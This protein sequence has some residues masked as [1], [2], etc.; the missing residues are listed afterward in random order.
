MRAI[1]VLILAVCFVSILLLPVLLVLGDEGFSPRPRREAPP[2][3]PGS[4][5]DAN[6]KL[7]P[8]LSFPAVTSAASSLPAQMIVET[9]PGCQPCER[10]KRGLHDLR[11]LGWNVGTDANDHFQ[12]IERLE[13]GLFP[14]ITLYQ[15]G[16]KIEVVNSHD[17]AELSVL[18]RKTW[19]NAGTPNVVGSAPVGQLVGVNLDSVIDRVRL[20]GITSAKVRWKR[21]ESTELIVGQ[22]W[23]I[24]Q[25]SG[26]SGHISIDVDGVSWPI[27]SAA[28]AYR[29]N[30]DSFTFD[31]DPIALRIVTGEAATGDPVTIIMSAISLARFLI[32]LLSPTLSIDLGRDIAATMRTTPTGIH[33]AF[34][35]GPAL[36][37]R[38]LITFKRKLTG[39]EITPAHVVAEFD[40]SRWWR[41]LTLLNIEGR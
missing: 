19:D 4:R 5:Q 14:R 21:N 24:Q 30:G 40:E 32:P 29:W 37:I 2:T 16:Q 28:C 10:L 31:P 3:T 22:K 41:R 26:N 35:D 34:T 25:V 39:L 33:I 12:L 36:S 9:T 7:T 6:E 27:T 20:L 38:S 18:L 23:T 11:R 1:S 15:H 13:G 17:P 8:G